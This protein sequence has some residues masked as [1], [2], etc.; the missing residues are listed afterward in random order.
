[1]GRNTKFSFFL[2]PQTFYIYICFK[3]VLLVDFICLF[4]YSLCLTHCFLLISSSL[5]PSQKLL[6]LPLI[7]WLSGP[8][9][10]IWFAFYILFFVNY[11]WTK[12]NLLERDLNLRPPFLLRSF[13]TWLTPVL[14]Y[15]CCLYFVPFCLW[16]TT[17]L[18]SKRKT[19]NNYFALFHFLMFHLNNRFSI[20]PN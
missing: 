8:R 11:G 9:T 4:V 17:C 12:T 5:P 19:N 15:T 20:F 16:E 6:V 7:P 3:F 13:H 10:S 14:M 18:G 1:M 2:S